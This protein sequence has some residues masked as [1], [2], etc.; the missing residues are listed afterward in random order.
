ETT[1]DEGLN[2][3]Q[4]GRER[5]AKLVRRIRQKILAYPLE[6][7]KL[8]DIDQRPG[9]AIDCASAEFEWDCKEAQDSLLSTRLAGPGLDSANRM[10]SCPEDR[11]EGSVE[12]WIA[13]DIGQA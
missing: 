9:Y 4:D 6:F 10:L 1:F 2:I 8:G 5:R 13:G 7:F 3:S 11:A 12:L